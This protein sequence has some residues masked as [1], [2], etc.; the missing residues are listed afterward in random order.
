[1][2]HSRVWRVISTTPTTDNVKKVWTSD[3]GG[4]HTLRGLL[5]SRPYP[6]QTFTGFSQPWKAKA[7][8][9]FS[10]SH[11]S[12]LAQEASMNYSWIA[13][14]ATQ[15]KKI[16]IVKQRHRNLHWFLPLCLLQGTLIILRLSLFA[17]TPFKSSPAPLTQVELMWIYT[18]VSKDEIWS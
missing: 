9:L 12:K 4:L 11:Q 7:K 1:M 8:I 2:E 6:P 3:L 17:V 16:G 18:N 15:S 14:K 10:Q 13:H 5:D